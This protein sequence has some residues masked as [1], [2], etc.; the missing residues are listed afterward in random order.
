MGIQRTGAETVE[1][2]QVQNCVTIAKRERG[3]G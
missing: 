3:E 1:K 2:K